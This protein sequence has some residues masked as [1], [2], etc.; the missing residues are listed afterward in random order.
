[1]PHPREGDVVLGCHRGWN[2]IIVEKPFG[3]DLQSSNQL[4][5]HI[6]SLFHEDQI[7]RIDHY[8]GCN[9]MVAAIVN[10]FIMLTW[11]HLTAISPGSCLELLSIFSVLI[12]LSLQRYL[13][14]RR[15]PSSCGEYLQVPWAGLRSDHA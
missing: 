6:A 15:N 5:N 7:Y 2:R 14:T 3:R 1:M 11:N 9:T 10:L 4:S 12:H 13:N 8:L